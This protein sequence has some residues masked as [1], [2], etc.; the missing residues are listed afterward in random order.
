MSLDF[1]EKDV[2]HG[3]TAKY[4]QAFLPGAKK[5]FNAKAV[6][7]P[8]LDIH[9]IASKA[10]VYNINTSP[11][12]IENGLNAA[13]Q[14]INYLVADG[15]RIKT[16]LFRTRIRIP[17]EYD[18][19]ET[20]LPN[21]VYPEVRMTIAPEFREYIRE[22]VQ[23]TFDG[24]EVTDG[25]IG[26]ITDEFTEEVDQLITLGNIVAINGYGL[27][28]DCE[29]GNE[30]QVGVFFCAADGTETRAKA[31]AVSAPRTLKV[32]VPTGLID[33]DVYTIVVRTQ[34]SVKN[35]ANLLKEVR[36]VV[37]DT[38]LIAQSE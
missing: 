27:K 1:K 28:V 10:K 25:F 17:G 20:H 14:L 35:S 22:H 3:I 18:G 38:P 19:S 31:I 30:S 11:K 36:E 23:I 29:A 32:I 37:S 33:G 21:G 34:T 8:E 16:P 13:V 9:G 2:M 4:V 7:Q 24:V 26:Q 12:V 15:Y 5:G 6:F